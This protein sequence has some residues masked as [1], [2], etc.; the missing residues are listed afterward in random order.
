MFTPG[1]HWNEPKRFHQSRRWPQGADKIPKCWYEPLCDPA[2]ALMALRFTLSQPVTAAIPPGNENLFRMALTLGTQFTP[3]SKEE[4]RV[5]KERGL[6][7]DAT[8]RH[9]VVAQGRL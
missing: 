2:E 5:M 3:M 8:F 9:P 4:F 7:E 1:V 6:A